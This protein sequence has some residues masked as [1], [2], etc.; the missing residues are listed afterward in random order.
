[1][2]RPIDITSFRPTREIGNTVLRCFYCYGLRFQT[3]IQKEKE[4]KHVL[5]TNIRRTSSVFPRFVLMQQSVICICLLN[6]AFVLS[7]FL[8]S[9]FPSF[10]HFLLLYFVAIV[11]CCCC[12]LFLFYTYST[13]PDFPFASRTNL[14]TRTGS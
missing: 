3:Q 4:K 13:Q 7:F 2:V 1:M 11:C 9:F 14:Q 12:C 10:F 8:L 5:R 6:Q